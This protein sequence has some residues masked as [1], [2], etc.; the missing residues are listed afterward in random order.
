MK[1]SRITSYNVCYT[2]LLRSLAEK[3][4]KICIVEADLMKA[5]GTGS[6]QAKFPD[7]TFDVGVAEANRITSYNVC[8][9]KL[10]RVRDVA[11]ETY[12]EIEDAVASRS[13]AVFQ[14]HPF[15]RASNQVEWV[16]GLIQRDD[17]RAALHLN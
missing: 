14:D 6:F 2:K 7:R 16:R 1:K 12:R 4:E 10:L 9:T 15:L 5:T 8:Y 13:A 17:V 3:D 11:L